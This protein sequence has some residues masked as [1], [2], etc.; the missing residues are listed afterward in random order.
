MDTFYKELI[1]MRED[2]D[3]K[4]SDLVDWKQKIGTDLV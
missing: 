4:D 1:K 3:T 2:I